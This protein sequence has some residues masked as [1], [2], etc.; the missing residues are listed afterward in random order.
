MDIWAFSY[1]QWIW[2]N[3]VFSDKKNCINFTDK[4][5]LPSLANIPNF[6]QEL[7]I[8]FNMTKTIAIPSTKEQL[9]NSTLWG[10]HFLKSLTTVRL[11]L[12]NT[13]YAYTGIYSKHQNSV[14]FLSRVV[15]NNFTL[16]I[17]LHPVRIALPMQI[18]SSHF[19][20]VSV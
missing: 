15:S 3:I 7:I 11:F 6:Y 9:L 18:L 8:G 16:S 17:L 13:P 14:N 12:T 2:E 4:K 20:K 5:M 19:K 1:Y 10:N